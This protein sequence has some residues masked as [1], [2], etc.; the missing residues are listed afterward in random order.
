M[1]FW[2]HQRQEVL[3]M[4]FKIYLAEAAIAPAVMVKG[5]ALLEESAT[6]GA[7]GV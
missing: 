2:L 7:T 3:R 5:K 4:R 6:Q 1:S